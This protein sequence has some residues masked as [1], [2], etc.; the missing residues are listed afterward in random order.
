MFPYRFK[1]DEENTTL[2]DN[3]LT[4]II[5]SLGINEPEEAKK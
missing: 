1:E 4:V 2:N 5:T 3:H